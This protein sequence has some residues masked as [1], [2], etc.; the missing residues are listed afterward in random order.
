MNWVVEVSKLG[1]EW[2]KA[3]ECRDEIHANSVVRA[4]SKGD[5]VARAVRKA[6]SGVASPL[7][8]APKGENYEVHGCRVKF[9]IPTG[10]MVPMKKGG[11]REETMCCIQHKIRVKCKRSGRAWTYTGFK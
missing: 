8:V 3:T 2:R 1:G 11:V 10:N 5:Y 4:I 9:F 6:G 7:P